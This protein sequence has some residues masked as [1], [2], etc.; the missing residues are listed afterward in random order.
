M[1]DILIIG[2]GAAGFFTAI[3]CAERNP[4]LKIAILEK[5]KEVLSKVRISGGGRCNVT[6]AEFLPKN[7]VKN[8]PR[9]EKELLS[10]FH[11][12]MCG[13]VMEW[14]EGRGVPLKTEDDGRVFPQS[15]SSQSI[16]DCFLREMKRF[17]IQLF[18]AQNVSDFYKVENYWEVKTEDKRYQTKNLVLTTGSNPKIWNLLSKL[19]HT[20]VKPVPSL[21]TFNTSDKFIK[22]LAGIATTA[23]VSL[24]DLKD[25]PLKIKN[26]APILI[27]HWGFS[28]P[29]ILK[30]SAW[31]AR[32]LA[33]QNY[34]CILKVNWL[35]TTL[36]VPNQEEVV[37]Y[38]QDV[39]QN[40]SK[41]MTQNTPLFELP[42]RLWLRLLDKAGV[43]HTLLWAELNKGALRALAEVLTRSEFVINGKSVFKEEFVT[44]GG[45]ALSEI[46]FKTFESKLLPN[47][48]LAGEIIDVDAITGGF[49]FQNAWTGGYL[50]AEALAKNVTVRRNDGN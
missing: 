48:Y 46:D 25:K 20:I 13:D 39:K 30:L 35:A 43:P 50:I 41:K 23:E 8:Y 33:E 19:G 9:G 4:N 17:D 26:I 47:L 38:L 6:H 10:P 21:F 22:D 12:F 18:T 14:F 7:L 44:A 2:G 1:F 45:V 16:I 28:G 27:T 40:Q 5:G 11:K 37:H 34:Q 31:G 3:N 29:A 49:N 24:F 32:I 36:E 42:K 15:N